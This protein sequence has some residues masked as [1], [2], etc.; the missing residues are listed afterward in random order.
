MKDSK[1]I[2]T[3]M[4]QDSQRMG[5]YDPPG[6]EALRA[7]INELVDAL[8]EIADLPELDYT[9]NT[10]EEDYIC[11]INDGREDARQIARSMLDKS[12]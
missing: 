5:A 2:L 9:P 3:E 6:C 4:T 10:S 11:G 1:E 7:Y 12:N 8:Q